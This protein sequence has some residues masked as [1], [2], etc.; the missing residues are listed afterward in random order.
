[1]VSD[2]VGVFGLN[3]GRGKREVLKALKPERTD[4]KKGDPGFSLKEASS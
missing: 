4:Q 2:L 3:P 1:M